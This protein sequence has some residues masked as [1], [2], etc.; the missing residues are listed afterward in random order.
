MAGYLIE[1]LKTFFKKGKEVRG[2][3]DMNSID[4]SKKISSQREM[5]VE[6]QGKLARIQTEQGKN[7]IREEDLQ[8]EE[9]VKLELNEQKQEL[10]KKHYP[11]FVSLK[12]LFNK[13]Y[14]DSKFRNKLGIYTFDKSQKLDT[15]SDLGIASDGSFCLLNQKGEVVIKNKDLNKIFFNM[16]GLSNEL[17][18]GKIVIPFDAKGSHTPNILV[19]GMRDIVPDSD[20]RLKYT[21]INRK[22]LY[23]LMEEY[24]NEIS[25]NQDKIEEF[26]LTNNK[27]MKENTSLKIAQRVALD[28]AETS[29]KDISVMEKDVSAVNKIFRQTSKELATVRDAH[30]LAEDQIDK[31]ENQLKKAMDEAEKEGV[32]TS[33]SKALETVQNI[34]RELVRDEPTKEV[35][36]IEKRVPLQPLNVEK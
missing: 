25:E 7:R 15:F 30:H 4:N 18:D 34:K 29:H 28:N 23:K 36:I 19:E 33:Y 12:L 26:E 22:P 17:T 21:E 20:G 24:R 6:L 1:W 3:L 5:I 16:A 14:R 10:Q 8:E 32:K 27:L 35:Q 9:D 31:L 11:K 2:T 13:M